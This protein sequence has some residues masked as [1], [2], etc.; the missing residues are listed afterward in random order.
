MNNLIASTITIAL[1]SAAPASAQLLGGSGGLGGSLGGTLGGS[2]GSDTIGRTTGTI[3]GSGGV[4]SSTR[5]DRSIDTRSGEVATDADSQSSASGS[6]IG[7][8]DLPHKVV[9]GSA[10]GSASSSANG[11]AG[12]NLVGT[13]AVRS[14][15]GQVIGTARNTAG[16][17]RSAAIGAATNVVSNA[18]SAGSLAGQ[19]AGSGSAMAMGDLGQLAA[20]GSTAANAGGMFAIAPGMPIQDAKGR[21]VGH[22]RS[23]RQSGAG[24]VQS[25]IVEA[26]NRT[27]ELPAANFA[28]SGDVLVTGMSKG[29]IKEVSQ[30][31]STVPQDESHQ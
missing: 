14:T 4:T 22:V 13:D 3:T 21:I 5:I 20:S 31:Q 11:S 6:L 7:N 1:I 9:T 30:A 19:A 27:A 18:S 25:V 12:A 2:L 10:D 26:G 15:A 17:A 29:E 8:A 28:G 24:V 23:V 16:G